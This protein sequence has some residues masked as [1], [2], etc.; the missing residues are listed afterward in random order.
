M[1]LTLFQ[2]TNVLAIFNLCRSCHQYYLLAFNTLKRLFI[3]EVG[4]YGLF[5]VRVR[6]LTYRVRVRVRVRVLTYRVRVQPY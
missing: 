6:V 1:K 2:K 4:E 3:A 5:R